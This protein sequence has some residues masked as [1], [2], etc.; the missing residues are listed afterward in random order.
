MA[1]AA[2]TSSPA[3]PSAD[4]PGSFRPGRRTTGRSVGPLPLAPGRDPPGCSS[5][6]TTAPAIMHL[7]DPAVH[8]R[9][10]SCLSDARVA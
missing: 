6:V 7:R 9:V 5:S 4:S 8:P 3:G 2:P 1:R 10:W